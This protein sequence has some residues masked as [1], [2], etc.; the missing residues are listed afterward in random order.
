MSESTQ[1]TQTEVEKLR[2]R[3]N[4]VS[5]KIERLE[6]IVTKYE[7]QNGTTVNDLTIWLDQ[8]TSLKHNIDEKYTKLISALE[9]NENKFN[10]LVKEKTSDIS[11]AAKEA[12]DVFLQEVNAK[13]KEFK[14]DVDFISSECSTYF[15]NNQE[16]ISDLIKQTTDDAQSASAAFAEVKENE[17]HIAEIASDCDKQKDQINKHREAIEKLL[18]DAEKALTSATSA[19]L[20]KSFENRKNKLN[21]NMWKWFIALIVSLVLAAG[22]SYSRISELQK[23]IDAKE[24]ITGFVFFLNCAISVAA[25]AAPVWLAWLATKQIGY[26]FRLSEDYAFKAA[27][28]ASFEGFRKEI[29]ALA[30]SDEDNDKLRVQLLSTLLARFGEQPLRY[31]DAKVEGSPFHSLLP[32]VFDAIK[33]SKKEEQQ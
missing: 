23:L 17:Q 1:P 9:T 4:A 14:E 6:S 2:K 21:D 32:K 27:T 33:P 22:I 3:F 7:A 24:A 30:Q 19:G 29:E 18:S 25:I 31:V 12:S 10:L 5:D 16:T 20:A 26:N 13:R 11:S 15:K 28:A 8:V